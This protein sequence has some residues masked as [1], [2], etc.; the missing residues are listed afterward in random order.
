DARKLGGRELPV[1]ARLVR[2][3]NQWG[4]DK[5]PLI[6]V[7]LYLF[8]QWKITEVLNREHLLGQ[9]RFSILKYVKMEYMI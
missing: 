5:T 6:K 3:H 8:C 4:M 2:A 9:S 1:K 7:S